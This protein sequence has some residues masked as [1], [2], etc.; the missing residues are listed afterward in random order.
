MQQA[1]QAKAGSLLWYQERLGEPLFVGAQLTLREVAT[2]MC[3]AAMNHNVRQNALD[4]LL[5]YFSSLCQPQDSSFPP[6]TYICFKL[7][8]A[9][10]LHDVMY[11]CCGACGQH[12]IF[13]W[14]DAL[15]C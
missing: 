9:D 11:H 7:L 13:C 1:S 3:E 8:G 5:K 14:G 15:P 4:D 2:H 10:P 6:S 12:V